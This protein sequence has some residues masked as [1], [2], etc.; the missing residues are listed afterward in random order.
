VAFL[1]HKIGSGSVAVAL[2]A[3]LFFFSSALLSAENASAK[4][5]VVHIQGMILTP[6][7]LP[8]SP[9]DSVT[10]IN[11]DILLHAV[12][13]TD[14]KNAWQSKDLPPH[15]S[16]TKTCAEGC[17][18]ICPYHPTMSGEIVIADAKGDSDRH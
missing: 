7:K 18:Y 9:G 1:L 17:L 4:N 8:I 11:D 15:E 2:A 14:P 5:H 12:K 13:S 6:A 10:W 3:A 16:W